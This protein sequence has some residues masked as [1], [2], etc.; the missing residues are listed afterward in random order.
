LGFGV[1]DLV[2]GFEVWVWVAGCG[3]L[4][5]ALA[6]TAA[7]EAPVYCGAA[8]DGGNSSSKR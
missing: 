4:P 8:R 2:K 6:H 3:M 1:W 7:D 5:Q